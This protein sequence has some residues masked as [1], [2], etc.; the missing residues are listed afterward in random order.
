MKY[1]L[2]AMD[3]DGTLTNSDKII[4]PKTKQVLIELEKLGVKLVLASGRP[5]PG[6]YNF[7]KELE[8][9]KYGGYLLS[10]NGAAVHRY[11]SNKCIYSN[12]IRTKYILPII[13]NAKALGLDVIIYD[14]DDIVIDNPDTYKA[15]YEQR[16][17]DMGCKVVDDLR[18]Y[19]DFELNKLLITGKEEHL[20][21]VYDDFKLPFGDRLEICTSAPFYIEVVSNGI[22]KARGLAE[23]AL[24][25]GI[26]SEEMI[27]F[28]DEMNDYQMLDY[29]GHGVA[30]GNARQ[31]IKEIAD[32]VTLSN[33]EDGIAESLLA[34]FK[35][36]LK[37]LH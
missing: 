19:I 17:N 36:E 13:N 4:T 31:T 20:E 8:F 24:H 32:E 27:A 28:G 18:H 29:V 30:M 37:D 15:D 22:N 2:I 10:Y 33:D 23:I 26:K 5:T 11:P 35:E 9:D 21:K 3:L 34:I 7:A 6:L 25:E 12:T 16:I 14:K 1:K